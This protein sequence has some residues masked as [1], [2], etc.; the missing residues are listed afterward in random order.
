MKENY[1]LLS[2]KLFTSRA[3]LMSEIFVVNQTN[4]S[5]CEREKERKLQSCKE[6]G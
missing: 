5:V 2:Q 6:L 1:V 4:C 3:Y